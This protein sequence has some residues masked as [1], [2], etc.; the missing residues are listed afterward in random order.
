MFIVYIIYLYNK[1]Y[2]FSIQI[3]GI[4]KKVENRKKKLLPVQEI[5]IN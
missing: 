1:V 5:L 3:E 4:I 2:S